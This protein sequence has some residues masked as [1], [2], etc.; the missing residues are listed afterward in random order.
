MTYLELNKKMAEK[1]KLTK[2]ISV[3]E[4]YSKDF[5]E[6]LEIMKTEK[7]NGQVVKILVIPS[8]TR[9][10]EFGVNGGALAQPWFKKDEDVRVWVH[11]ELIDFGK[12]SEEN[13]LLFQQMIDHEIGH[14]VS[15]SNNFLGEFDSSNELDEREI[16]NVKSWL[17][18]MGI[19]NLP[20]ILSTFEIRLNTIVESLNLNILG[21]AAVDYS[22]FREDCANYYAAQLL[23]KRG[24]KPIMFQEMNKYLAELS[25]L[26]MS[27]ITGIDLGFLA[28]EAIEETKN[29][30]EEEFEEFKEAVNEEKKP[31]FNMYLK[32]C[33]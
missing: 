22:Q 16:A 33:M 13:G 27:N 25:I 15:L 21:M 20:H 1:N 28:N 10:R 8:N 17:K 6:L 2:Y 7:I 31:T 4:L 18:N 5:S 30:T 9:I 29:M 23:K 19:S 11:Q 14:L 32:W 26:V 3:E 12:E 24:E